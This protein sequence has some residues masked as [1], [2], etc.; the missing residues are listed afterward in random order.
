[1][2][3]IQPFQGLRYN[4]EKVSAMDTVVAP[5]YDVISP[6]EQKALHEKSPYNIVRL[7]LGLKSAS[8]TDSNNIYTRAHEVL[9]AWRQQNVLQEEDQ[10]AFYVYQQT[11]NGIQ[12]KG[13]IARLQ[14]EPYETGAIL[15]HE[16]TLGGPKADRLAL[17]QATGTI[18]S[19]IFCL[20]DDPQKEVEKLL[21]T[22]SPNQAIEV[23]DQDGVFHQFW[24]VCESAL[25][26]R[27]H[28]LLADKS[29]LIADGHHRYETA[30]AH[31]Q[32][33]RKQEGQENVPLGSLPWDYTMA[34]FTNMADEG[35]RIYPTH[36][37]FSTFPQGWTGEAL[38]KGLENYFELTDDAQALF[39]VETGKQRIKTPYRLKDTID[40][41][42]IPP[43][44]QSLDV[45]L[46]D[47]FVF[48]ALLQQSA[49]DL[50]QQGFLHFIRE[51]QE[52]VNLLQNDENTLVFWVHAPDVAQVKA[53]C[54]SGL[55]MPQK[56]T[57]F[58]PKLLSGLVMYYYGPHS[59]KTNNLA[60]ANAAI[61]SST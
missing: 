28:Q 33:R 29:V 40:R 41:S 22:G 23:T 44:L 11:W 24:P 38:L 5:P 57:Y 39:W 1:M 13:F 15:P 37:V 3:N 49:N 8:D 50:K 12:R 59:L 21:F 19:P 31:Q 36:R 17:T 4:P 46:I 48:Q 35:L 61:A 55:R 30:I 20:Y 16:Y 6:A 10:S 47:Q 58:Y 7:I 54:E 52:I 9:E 14:I 43:L 45:A 60:S 25:I 27:I 2:V 26:E 42:I 51:E 34:F 18:L 53:I 32:W 56:S